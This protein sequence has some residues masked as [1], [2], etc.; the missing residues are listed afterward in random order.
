MEQKINFM[1]SKRKKWK[2]VRKRIIEKEISMP[3]R[4]SSGLT[5]YADIALEVPKRKIKFSAVVLVALIPCR[6]EIVQYNSNLFWSDDDYALFKQNTISEI[7]TYMKMFGVDSKLAVKELYQPDES[8]RY[9]K[10]TTS[11][12][13]H[14]GSDFV[15]SDHIFEKNSENESFDT[16]NFIIDSLDDDAWSLAFPPEIDSVSE[17]ASL[18]VGKEETMSFNIGQVV[19]DNSRQLPLQIADPPGEEISHINHNKFSVSCTKISRPLGVSL[20]YNK[21]E[22][23]SMNSSKPFKYDPNSPLFRPFPKDAVWAIR[24]RKAS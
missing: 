5:S 19:C 9:Q 8:V 21:A 22:V 6:E 24:W 10:F 4:L 2:F 14:V 15:P 12:E 20:S 23:V 3:F 18:K 11:Q 13:I 17:I 7:H 1:L 16:Q